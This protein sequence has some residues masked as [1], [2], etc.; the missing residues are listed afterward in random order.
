MLPSL[1]GFSCGN[2]LGVS[3]F[4]GSI[5][6]YVLLC[7]FLNS[8]YVMPFFLRLSSG[9]GAGSGNKTNRKILNMA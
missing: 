7:L 2:L 8:S 3:A 6:S 4:G 5:T 1:A 9:I